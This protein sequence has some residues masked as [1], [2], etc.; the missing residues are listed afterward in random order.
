M[1]T[2]FFDLATSPLRE[3]ALAIFNAGLSAVDIKKTAEEKIKLEDGFLKIA[4]KK[5]NLKEYKRI[6]LVA[7]GKGS[8]DFALSVSKIIG[9]KLTGGFALDVK[10]PAVPFWE[11]LPEEIN[12][13]VG[14]HPLPSLKN[15]AAS[16][17]IIRMIDKLGRGD[18][19]LL[20]VTGGGSSLLCGSEEEMENAVHLTKLLT[21]A[22]APIEE[23]NI[24][25]KHISETKGGNLAKLA[26]PA[27]IISLIVS[28]VCFDNEKDG[29][30]LVSSGPSFFDESTVLDARNI[31]SKYGL[32]PLGFDFKETPKDKM[33][34]EDVDNLLFSSNRDALIGMEKEAELLGFKSKIFSPNLRGEAKN[35]FRRMIEEI[36]P[37]EAL[38]SGGETVV[39]IKNSGGKGGR[40]Q[41]AV[42]GSLDFLNFKEYFDKSWLVGSLASDSR[43][44]GE[45]AGALGDLALLENAASK[46]IHYKNFLEAHNEF[47]YFESLNGLIFAEQKSFNVA[48]LMLVLREK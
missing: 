47:P 25:R 38:I 46:K 10:E 21:R 27:K 8:G 40:N 11:T 20:L 17:R 41:E 18:L 42:L 29:L 24:V 28:D 36:N 33:L 3:K 13:L 16:K 19:L 34:F 23:L 7:F 2:N 37:G 4:G 5:Y 14:S 12:F 15:V 1:I 48:D 44:N 22:G 45:A 39:T 6:F 35:V 43:D 32:N 9:H 26:Y 30:P 31:L